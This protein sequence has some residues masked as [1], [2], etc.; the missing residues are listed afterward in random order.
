[1]VCQGLIA[2]HPGKPGALCAARLST[3]S[4]SELFEDILVIAVCFSPGPVGSMVMSRSQASW[5]RKKRLVARTVR[6]EGLRYEREI[7][8]M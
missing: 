1:M 5:C 3:F 8:C 2:V 7:V 6:R 4:G